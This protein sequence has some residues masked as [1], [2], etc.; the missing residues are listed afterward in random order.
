MPL[1]SHTGYSNLSRIV[2]TLK[3]T[4]TRPHSALDPLKL[5]DSRLFAHQFCSRSTQKLL[6]SPP[7]CTRYTLNPWIHPHS[8]LD[9]LWNR[10]FAPICPRYTQKPLDSP[11]VCSGS[12]LKHWICPNMP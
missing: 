10:G 12:T 1:N 9:P 5:P 4:W 7:P 11:S 3:T 2:N 6:E 8:A